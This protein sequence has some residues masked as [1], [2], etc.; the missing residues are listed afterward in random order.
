MGTAADE[1]T[2]TTK[3]GQYLQRCQVSLR[4]PLTTD[5]LRRMSLSQFIARVDRRGRG[6]TSLGLR[7]KSNIVKEKPYLQL[8]LRKRGVAD[9][10]RQCLRLQRAFATAGD[11]PMSLS[12]FD[13]IEQL[14]AFVK[15]PQCPVWLKKRFARH[16][17]VKRQSAAGTSGVVAAVRSGN[18][19][20]ATSQPSV[21]R[22]DDVQVVEPSLD[23]DDTAPMPGSSRDKSSVALASHGSSSADACNASVPVSAVS[24][25]VANA[26][27]SDVVVEPPVKKLKTQAEV[28]QHVQSIDTR[29]NRI[30]VAAQHDL[31]WTTAPGDGRYSVCTAIRKHEPKPSAMIMRQ[32]V[33]ALTQQ[34][35]PGKSKTVD[36]M[37]Q[38]VYL[39]LHFD[40]LP[41]QK[42]GAGVTKEGLPKNALDTLCNAY[43]A[44]I[45]AKA[46][47][48]Q[49]RNWLQ[50][51]YA[52]LWNV[53]KK[54]T[55]EQ[56]GFGCVASRN[57][58][59]ALLWRGRHESC[60]EAWAMV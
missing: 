39:V 21:S 45:G 16:N 13:A 55:L 15:Q 38:Y 31:L 47:P 33:Q 24:Q 51:P 59:E 36:L 28:V 27:L 49:K 23:D 57:A 14:Q 50:M 42:R 30:S 40:L 25:V 17:R 5:M 37:E 48:R 6:R 32:Y 54:H 19:A 52:C 60:R 2:Q 35:P 9:M 20:V 10:A 11:D 56:C 22:L 12:D 34:K 4:S 53:L 8:D 7:V 46:E 3:L 43:F 18:T 29:E 1:A 41:Y 44:G 26:C 58:P